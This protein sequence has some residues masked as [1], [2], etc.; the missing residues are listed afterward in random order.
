MNA[1]TNG[2]ALARL[3]VVLYADDV[4]VAASDDPKLWVETLES[5]VRAEEEAED[6]DDESP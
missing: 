6:E 5:V 4:M 2:T 3:R 1:N